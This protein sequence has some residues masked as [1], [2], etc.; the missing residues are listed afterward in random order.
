MPPR[1]T[2]SEAPVIEI[3]SD[4][5]C[6]SA[7]RMVAM[8]WISLRNPFGNDG[9]SGRSISRAVRMAF[10][11]G[12]PSRRKNE[13]GIFPTAYMRSST[14]TVSGK[15]SSCSFGLRDATAVTST[16]V[17]ATLTAT[18]PSARRASLPDSNRYVFS[19][20]VRS[21]VN[22]AAAMTKPP[23]GPMPVGFGRRLARW[24]GSV[25]SGGPPSSRLRWL[26]T[27]D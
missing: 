18:A 15:K 9:R 19:P 16:S 21:T 7:D 24:C 8:T 1:I 5:F 26:A 13:P 14:S 10:S 25:L 11:D 22:G 2:A 6:W 12:L 27:E 20:I 17:S 23:S 3:T 4:W